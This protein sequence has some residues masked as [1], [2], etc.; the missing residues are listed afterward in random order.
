LVCY[1]FIRLL[2][3]SRVFR[4]LRLKKVVLAACW[5]CWLVMLAGYVGWLHW[6]VILAGYVGWLCWLA[7]LAGYVGWLCWL[8]VLAGCVGWLCWLVMLAG[9]VGC[10]GW[11]LSCLCTELSSLVDTC[12][13]TQWTELCVQ[14]MEPGSAP[15]DFSEALQE[16]LTLLA[17]TVIAF[18][19]VA[20]G[21]I[22][23]VADMMY[24]TARPS[25]MLCSI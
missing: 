2:R 25:C 9:C 19:F 21:L 16:Q 18:L 11:N 7:A 23:T 5:L 1:S 17:F 12:W 3:G 6:L 8:V 13:C 20:T 14:A 10:I 24:A 15:E 22:Y 4:V